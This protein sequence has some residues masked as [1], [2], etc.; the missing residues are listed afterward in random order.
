MDKDKFNIDIMYSK[1]E[2]LISNVEERILGKEYIDYFMD[3]WRYNNVDVKIE[4]FVNNITTLL[5]GITYD[6]ILDLDEELSLEVRTELTEEE[7]CFYYFSFID[8]IIGKGPD[9]IYD[10]IWFEAMSDVFEEINQYIYKY[11][12]SDKLK[13]QNIS[14]FDALMD[15]NENELRTYFGFNGREA[16][17]QYFKVEILDE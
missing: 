17:E 9:F 10:D 12:V 2:N 4:V 7:I 8:N 3:D 13:E 16:Q 6:E 11:G 14:F 1:L 15:M 5:Y